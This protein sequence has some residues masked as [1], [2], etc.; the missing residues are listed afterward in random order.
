MSFNYPASG[1]NN[2]AEYMASGLPFATQSITVV[3]QACR[4]DF[5]FV[6]KFFTVKNNGPGTIAIGF[7]ELG[8]LGTNRF[9]LPPSGAY[10]GDLRIKT[11]YITTISGAQS[12]FECIAGLTQILIR[13]FPTLTGSGAGYQPYNTDPVY[14]YDGLG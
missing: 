8:T 2:V 12:G 5:P 7:T 11:V 1:L 13:G 14:G 9:S 4:V 6:T 10:Q 3:S